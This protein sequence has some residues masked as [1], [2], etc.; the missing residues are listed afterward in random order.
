M[1]L[2]YLDLLLNEPLLFLALLP[3]ILLT[4]GVALLT[5]ITVH[6]FSH[7]WSAYMLGDPTARQLGR[8]S[9][10]PR[11]HMDPAGTLMI[12]LVGF[13]WGKPTPVNPH[14]LHY[15]GRGMMLVS[16]AGPIS[17]LLM[18]FLLAL[19]FRFG[20][21][22]LPVTSIAAPNIFLLSLPDI[23]A[24][25]LFFTIYINIV[26][27]VFNLLPI[28]PLD[29]FKVTVGLLPEKVAERFLRL[30][31]YG[32]VLLM[33]VILLDLGFG[34]G[35]LSRILFPPIEFFVTLVLGI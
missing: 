2:R 8:L 5:A 26:L 20:W 10:N 4:M 34:L 16:L 1:L 14:R 29:G 17:N 15:G 6:E 7:A 32:P 24:S 9:L 18:A 31:A 3:G 27:M 30:E 25:V 11:V 23:I 21:M 13:G 33:G 22:S 12:I 19:V 35:I 28:S